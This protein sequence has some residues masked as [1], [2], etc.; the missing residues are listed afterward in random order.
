MAMQT[1]KR[2]VSL[3]AGGALLLSLL[4][5]ISCWQAVGADLSNPHAN[6]WRAARHGVSGSTTVSSEG[7]KVL[8]Q[9]GGENWRE[10]RDGLLIR[11]SQWTLAV[12][13]LALGLFYIIVGK[14]RLENP[15]SGVKIQRYTL[16]E[17]I[18]HWCT[19]LLFIVMA[20]T[21]LSLLLGRVALI[22]VFGHPAV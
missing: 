22:P 15:R 9:N 14:D 10:I 13:L 6:L 1:R 18:L 2:A 12:V 3:L 4:I 16:G 20:V 19:A 8:I 21:G 5:G 7:H 11:F 17:R